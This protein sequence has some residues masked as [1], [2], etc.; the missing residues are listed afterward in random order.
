MAGLRRII[1]HWTGG[2]HRATVLDK[3]HY[4]F[5]IEGDG[6]LVTGDKTPED[7]INVSDGRY[8]AHTRGCN[9][10][11]IGVAMAAMTGAVDDM[12][13]HWGRFPMTA[14]Q[15]E[16][17]CRVVADLCEKYAIPVTRQTVLT[18]AEV[19]PTL[20]IRQSGKWDIRCLPGDTKLRPAVEVGDVLRRRIEALL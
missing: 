11:S 2:G 10:G 8:A 18:H 5:I 6:K 19:F 12:P 7:N 9:T 15:I 4:H 13:L 3:Q 14:I 17:F 1:G 20:G 16:A